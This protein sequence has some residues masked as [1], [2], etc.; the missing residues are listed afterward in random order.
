[1]DWLR[2]NYDRVATFAAATFLLLCAF[3][4]WR[5]ATAFTDQFASVQSTGPQQPAAPPAKAVELDAAAQKLRQP[6]Q[7]T[8][9]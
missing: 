8:F 4:I 7:W 9:S 2:S 3:F 5:S 6:P 1:M